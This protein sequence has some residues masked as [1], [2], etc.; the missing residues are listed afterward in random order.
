MTITFH[1]LDAMDE[2][3]AQLKDDIVGELE[4]AHERVALLI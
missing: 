2:L 4:A 1:V 3:P